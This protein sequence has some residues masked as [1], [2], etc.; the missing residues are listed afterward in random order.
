MIHQDLGNVQ[1]L[2]E[3]V[4]MKKW[5]RKASIGCAQDHFHAAS[6]WGKRHFHETI[7]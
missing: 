5:R 2:S 7:F 4:R 3:N 1:V 6:L